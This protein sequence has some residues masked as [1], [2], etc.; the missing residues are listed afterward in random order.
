[1]AVAAAAEAKFPLVCLN[2]YEYKNQPLIP[3][4]QTDPLPQ[5]FLMNILGTVSPTCRYIDLRSQERIV[6]AIN[7]LKTN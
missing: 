2:G 1:M 7:D 4:L 5:I 3:S 6:E